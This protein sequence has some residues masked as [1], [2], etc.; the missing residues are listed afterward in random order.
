MIFEQGP[1]VRKQT[2]QVSGTIFLERK[3]RKCKT[4]EAEKCLAFWENSKVLV[5]LQWLTGKG[6][7]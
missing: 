6:E 5:S 1:E 3:S 4:S 7:T 2:M